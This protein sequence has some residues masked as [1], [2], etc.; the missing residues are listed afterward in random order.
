MNALDWLMGLEWWQAELLFWGAVAIAIA[1]IF[2]PDAI[3]WIRT[4]LLVARK[5]ASHPNRISK[6]SGA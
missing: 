5:A 2:I 3:S 4:R 1:G 6:T